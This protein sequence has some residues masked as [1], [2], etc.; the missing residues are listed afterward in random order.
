[1]TELS[2]KTGRSLNF[3]LNAISLDPSLP[4]LPRSEYYYYQAHADPDWKYDNVMNRIIQIFYDHKSRYG[5]RRITLQLIREGYRVNHKLIKRLKKMGLYGATPKAKYKSYKGD[6]NGTVRN[7]LLSKEVDE[8]EHKTVYLYHFETSH[9]NEKWT[10]DVSEAHIP[11][12][13]LYRSPILDM[14]NGEIVSYD[15]SVHPNYQQI[16]NMLHKAF[17]KYTN[18]K[19]LI[20]HSNQGWQY[21]MVQYHKSLKDKG[22]LQ[23]MSRKENCLDN[24]VMENLF[25]K[26]KNEMFYGHEYEFK[27]LDQ[28]KKAIEYYNRERIQVRLKGLTPCQARADPIIVLF[29]FVQLSGFTIDFVKYHP[30][31]L[32]QTIDCFYIRFPT[33]M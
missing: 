3:I 9:P 8:E 13:K 24:C 4:H 7:L 29:Y 16:A 23:S 21:Q 5:Y 27:T 17:D 12:G 14:Y 6:F 19:G 26:L 22:I 32:K 28:L 2:Q 1:M 25:G 10:T 18:L 20:F 15:V 11:A 33:I 31:F 30:V